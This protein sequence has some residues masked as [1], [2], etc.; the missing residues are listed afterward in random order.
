MAIMTI[1]NTDKLPPISKPRTLNAHSFFT[2][3]FKCLRL[4]TLHDPEERLFTSSVCR[5]HQVS[6]PV[7][8][9]PLLEFRATD[10]LSTRL[11]APGPRDE[12]V[13]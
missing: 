11:L 12:G 6:A 4:V 8:R 13:D 10:A 7:I 3:M 5:R 9:D 1:P 2:R